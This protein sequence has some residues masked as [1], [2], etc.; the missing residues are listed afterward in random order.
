MN[1]SEFVDHGDERQLQG[2]MHEVT[3]AVY[4]SAR[5]SSQTLQIAPYI[6]NVPVGRCKEYTAEAL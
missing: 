6:A 2:C 1:V 3:N 4:E 5:I